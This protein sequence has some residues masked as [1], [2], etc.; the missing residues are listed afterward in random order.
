MHGYRY[1]VGV[2]ELFY[3][4]YS[5]ARLTVNCRVSTVARTF[6]D[7]FVCASSPYIKYLYNK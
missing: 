1:E 4:P 7:V 2:C 3:T 6:P 5:A